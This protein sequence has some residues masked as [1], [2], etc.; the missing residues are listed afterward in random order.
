M[1]VDEGVEVDEA[2]SGVFSLANRASNP[3]ALAA[4]ICLQDMLVL[5]VYAFLWWHALLEPTLLASRIAVRNKD[6]FIGDALHCATM[7]L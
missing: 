7:A 6:D 5:P 4:A 3:A 1:E 2:V